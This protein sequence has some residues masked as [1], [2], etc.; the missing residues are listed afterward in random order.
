MR[1]SLLFAFALFIIAGDHL[2][3]CIPGY[4]DCLNCFY[5]NRTNSLYCQST[6]KCLPAKSSQCPQSQAIYRDYQ[7]VE[8]FQLCTNVTFS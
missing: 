1:S 6:K 4:K 5:T 2:A 7:C 8:G 3:Q